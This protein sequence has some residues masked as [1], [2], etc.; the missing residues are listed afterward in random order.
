[1][2]SDTK[3]CTWQ[4]FNGNFW[5]DFAEEHSEQLN[6]ALSQGK[7]DTVLVHNWVN[8]KKKP[9]TTKYTVNFKDYTQRNED[10]WKIR[11]VRCIRIEVMGQGQVQDQGSW[12]S[13]DGTTG[14]TTR[15]GTPATTQHVHWS[16]D[17]ASND[18]AA[19]HDNSTDMAANHDN[20]NEMAT[21][22]NEVD[23]NH[24]SMVFERIM[25]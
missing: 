11:P 6:S 17:G 20:S 22:S 15:Q 5:V 12:S 1:M 8:K 2:Q 9:T 4:W 7:E 19:N 23:S 16:D 3:S 14:S 13:Y 25:E 21:N 24:N 18:M 10:S